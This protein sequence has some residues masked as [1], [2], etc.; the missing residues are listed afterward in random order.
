MTV[1]AID[2]LIKLVSIVL[3]SIIGYWVKR[4]F[5]GKANLI[6]YYVHA[7]AIPLPLAQPPAPSQVNTHTIV[8]KNIGR[9][10]AKNVR[11]GHNYLPSSHQ[12]FPQISYQIVGKIDGVAE[13]L[14]PTLVPNEE[15][16]ISYLYFP[17]LVYTGVNSYTKFDEGSARVVNAIPTPQPTN[18]AK[19][20]YLSLMF[21]GASTLVYMGINYVM[22]YFI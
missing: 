15:I 19:F 6:T 17:P 22:S 4:V 8:V 16:S 7:S 1:A 20:I 2:L 3:T 21:I 12:V 18:L 10:T 9:V 14:I 13:I 11:V 5:E